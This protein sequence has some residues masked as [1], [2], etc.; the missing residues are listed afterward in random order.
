MCEDLRKSK[1]QRKETFFGDD[2][3]TYLVENDATIF[4]KLL[5]FLMQNIWIRPLRLKLTQ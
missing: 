5:V 1:R 3:Y 2:C 4:Y